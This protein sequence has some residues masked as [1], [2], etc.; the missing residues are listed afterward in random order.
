MSE[1]I[2]YPCAG[3]F[4]YASLGAPVHPGVELRTLGEVFYT[5][6]TFDDFFRGC[7][8]GAC[9]VMD[10]NYPDRR[11][12]LIPAKPT[13][14]QSSRVKLPGSRQAK[15]KKPSQSPR[16]NQKPSQSPRSNQVGWLPWGMKQ[17]RD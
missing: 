11:E 10:S 7:F 2:E 12:A 13:K 6:P 4:A 3:P 15:N 16:S 5:R 9:L 17:K 14:N 1:V 8:A